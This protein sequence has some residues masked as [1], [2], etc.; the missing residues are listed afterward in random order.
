[1]VY[2]CKGVE[3][4]SDKPIIL[5]VDDDY[6]ICGLIKHSLEKTGE[7]EVLATSLPKEVVNLCELK[8]PDLII[9]DIV[10]PDLNGQDLIKILQ[11]NSTTKYIKIIVTSGLGEMFY[12]NK[13]DKWRW[14]PNKSIADDPD[15]LV[16]ERSA[17]RAALAYGVDDYLAKPFTPETLRQ[18]VKDVLERMKETK[19]SEF[20]G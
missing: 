13:K 14:L 16:H 6:E 12:F 18:V 20:E 3:N 8:K 15:K 10:M 4:M 11:K 1:M 19:P 9:L 2:F 5:V 17:E 7:Y